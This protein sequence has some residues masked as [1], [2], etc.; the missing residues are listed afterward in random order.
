MAPYSEAFFLALA[1]ARRLRYRTIDRAVGLRVH[2]RSEAS[3]ASCVLDALEP[4]VPKEVEATPKCTPNLGAVAK[5]ALLDLE[6][7]VR[8][9]IAKDLPRLSIGAL[10]EMEVLEKSS[11]EGLE[12]LW[13]EVTSGDYV[14]KLMLDAANDE[15][16]IEQ[17]LR[18]TT[19]GLPKGYFPRDFEVR[20]ACITN[21][22]CLW[23]AKHFYL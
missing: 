23:L 15:R 1:V 16:S 17:R 5:Y 6:F 22:P 19:R 20:D 11:S 10:R 12:V 2:V 7:P 21:G 13:E 3:I 18:D 9:T 4:W 14:F 8:S